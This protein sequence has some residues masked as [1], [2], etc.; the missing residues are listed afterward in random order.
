VLERPTEEDKDSLTDYKMHGMNLLHPRRRSSAFAPS[1]SARF[2]LLVTLLLLS[3]SSIP[4][5]QSSWSSWWLDEQLKTKDTQN[6]NDDDEKPP[7]EELVSPLIN[8]EIQ[9]SIQAHSWPTTPSSALCEAFVYF[10]QED[11]NDDN[12][13]TG[14]ADGAAARAYL[15]AL[16]EILLSQQQQQPHEPAESSSFND[17]YARS[18]QLALTAASQA[19]A[20]RSS[21]DGTTST[22]TQLRL[23]E[24]SLAMRAA[25]PHCE[26]FRSL[27][28]LHLQHP[29]TTT[30]TAINSS[31][32]FAVVYPRQLVVPLSFHDAAAVID[33]KTAIQNQL[34][35][36][37]DDKTNTIDALVPGEVPQGSNSNGD[38]DASN[39]ALV[40]LYANLGTTAFATHY[41]ALQQSGVPFV[42]RHWDDTATS[43][44]D[45]TKQQRQQPTTLQGYGV[46]L[47]IRNVEYK[48]FDDR[49]ADSDLDAEHNGRINVTE[50]AASGGLKGVKQFLAGVNLTALGLLNDDDAD[51]EKSKSQRL[52]QAELWKIHDQQQGH[53]QI[54]PPVWQRRKLPLQAAT[55]IAASSDPLVTLETVSQNLPSVASMLVHVTMDDAVQQAAAA[56]EANARGIPMLTR[57]GRLYLNGRVAANLERPSLNVFELLNEIRKEQRT[58]QTLQQKLGPV[59]N[60]NVAALKEVQ[61]A[62]MMGDEF[63]KYGLAGDANGGDGVDNRQDA[64][65][66]AND[67]DDTNIFRI[68][69]GR[70]WKQAV[71][72][73]NDVEKDVQYADWSRSL[74]QM[75]M[76]MQF[77]MPPSVR[78]NLFTIL[79]VV[80]PMQAGEN[81]GFTLGMQ[82][83]QSS[84]P[85]RVGA[86]VVGEADIQACAAW[87]AAQQPQEST[88]NGDDS[89]V[90]PVSPIFA[91][92]PSSLEDLKGIP[93]T[94]QAVHRLISSVA[95]EYGSRFPQVMV[96]YMEYLL[97]SIGDV[98]DMHDLVDSHVNLI[99]GMGIDAGSDL[100]AK[101]LDAL[102]ADNAEDE[103]AHYSYGKALRFAVDK[104][105][106]PGMSFLNGRP[107]P[108]DMDAVGKFFGEE[109]NHIFSLIMKGEITDTSPKSVYAKLLS[110]DRVFKRNHPLLAQK[111]ATHREIQHYFTSDSLLLA[112]DTFPAEADAY[113]LVE[114]F[115][116]FGGST[117]GLKLAE[118]FLSVLG[119]LPPSIKNSDGDDTT[120]GAVYRVLPSTKSAAE[121]SL[122]PLFAN[123]HLLG[124]G[125]LQKLLRS[126][127]LPLEGLRLDA[128]L[129][130]L[131]VSDEISQQISSNI[132]DE[133]G[134]SYIENQFSGSNLIVANGRAYKVEGSSFGKGDMDLL[135]SMELK[136]S[137]AVTSLLRKHVSFSPG[138]DAVA[139]S[140]VATFLSMESS[141]E[142]PART[143]MIRSIEKLESRL[144][145]K[146][147]P[148]RFSWN[149]EPT[150]SEILQVSL[151]STFSWLVS[152]CIM[153]DTFSPY[154]FTLF[155]SC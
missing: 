113:F 9:T 52:L 45:A 90:C 154:L 91:T 43:S 87:L 153:R 130:D 83:M 38:D 2:F 110:G 144:E 10:Q 115:L 12:A 124:A 151:Y 135:L 57:P 42:V 138:R 93:A 19:I 107:V 64:E 77:G 16:A 25:S 79:A 59:L 125:K 99:E 23:L 121:S 108:S 26:L 86:L 131:D 82:L 18:V 148:I 76:N 103:S 35:P 22:T 100:H 117:D 50:A 68:D 92:P 66:P 44:N 104:G 20:P 8:R 71:M 60:N 30:T 17:D 72:Y 106:Q 143:N 126:I 129:K 114:A 29:T 128:L 49:S 65:D 39:D 139:V 70:G 27:T 142:K 116:D 137:K 78:R 120:I 112:G 5:A 140:Q 101:T 31:S 67:D 102:K 74:R 69:V 4:C 33:W 98:K 34:I 141:D 15:D 149:T 150:S 147:N 46:R 48:V 24:F 80:D 73:L 58:L 118:Q 7:L 155:C 97:A 109:Q 62:W 132:G 85:A 136:G 47:D 88:D 56:L 84:Y 96:A 14:A 55:V 81:T 36:V 53:S 41:R 40:I 11:E 127:S 1:S 37:N 122:C 152:V 21:D 61:A 54:V 51:D 63:V 111:G 123:A 119:S 95:S 6:S 3:S 105:L 13:T 75:M 145:I 133:S 146:P 94:T 32:I 28:T 89:L 134:C